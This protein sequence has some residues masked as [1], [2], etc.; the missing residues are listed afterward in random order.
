M[1][2]KEEKLVNYLEQLP[3]M[4]VPSGFSFQVMDR[5]E[6]RQRRSYSFG[7]FK[8][9]AIVSLTLVFLVAL[10]FTDL[11][12]FPQLNITGISGYRRVELKFYA[13]SENPKTVAVAGDFSDWNTLQ[14]EKKDNNS[15]VITLKVKPG[16]YQYSFVIDGKEW[17]PD[18]RSYRKIED[19]FG[20]VN[21]VLVVNGG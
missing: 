17:V 5:I 20:G 3:Q 4:L 12:L 14:M 1:D 7:N 13:L 10:F 21:S 16:K 2:R 8:K 9:L 15:W 6:A 11:P 19:G 18:P